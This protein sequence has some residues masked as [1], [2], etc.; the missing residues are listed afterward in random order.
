MICGAN[1]LFSHLS[2]GYGLFPPAGVRA[3]SPEATSW[4][5]ADY[6]DNKLT[7]RK[8]LKKINHSLQKVATTELYYFQRNDSNFFLAILQSICQ[9]DFHH[10]EKTQSG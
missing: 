4:G 3:L 6:Y 9:L 7:I 1:S 2:C 10:L 5:K 8:F